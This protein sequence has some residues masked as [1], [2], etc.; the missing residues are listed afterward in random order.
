V[1]PSERA[2]PSAEWEKTDLENLY[3]TVND[4]NSTGQQE[5]L[6][7]L[8]ETPAVRENL[9]NARRHLLIA[10]RVCPMMPDVDLQLAMLDF[11]EPT[12]SPQGLT[13]LQRAISLNRANPV[14]LDSIAHLADV[15][16]MIDI[17]LGCW[18][19]ELELTPDAI[20]RIAT[21]LKGRV[22]IEDQIERVFPASPRILMEL[23]TTLYANSTDGNSRELL[24]QRCIRM[25]IEQRQQIVGD[26]DP[27]VEIS[28]NE[29]EYFYT[30]GQAHGLLGNYEAAVDC[31]RQALRISPTQLN[32]RLELVNL[33]RKQ[34]RF[35][36]AVKQAELCLTID[37]NRKETVE[38]LRQIHTEQSTQSDE[39]TESRP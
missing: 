31:F 4:W 27:F 38:L 16:G 37:P 18:R 15:A 35:A 1:N 11:L 20:Q 21:L 36:A 17:A 24:L 5:R 13:H 14:A 22:S 10:Q 33:L 9:I 6:A 26:E 30:L 29:A 12:V 23:A 25:L 32:W 19:R 8:R 39:S 28:T 34:R 7:E 3:Q 2:S